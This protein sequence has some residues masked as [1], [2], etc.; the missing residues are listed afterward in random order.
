M[1]QTVIHRLPLVSSAHADG[2][3]LQKLKMDRRLG[4]FGTVW[5][6]WD[7]FL[8][9]TS[10]FRLATKP[11]SSPSAVAVG[12]FGSARP[13]RVVAGAASATLLLDQEEQMRPATIILACALL[14]S[15]ATGF[16]PANR[17]G[18]VQRRHVGRWSLPIRACAVGA[19][20]E[21]DAGEADAGLETANRVLLL[22]HIN[23]NHEKGRHDT[24]KAFYFDFLGCAIDPRKHENYL[25]GTKTVWANIGAS[26]SFVPLSC[27]TRNPTHRRLRRPP[28]ACSNSIYPRESPTRKCSTESSRLS[29]TTLK[30]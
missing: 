9:K 2:R 4:D 25:A 19:D 1:S 28:Q 26:N 5:G 29:M 21:A 15:T 20:V 14:L 27:C 8:M 6:F 17:C 24:L 12:R 30:I 18:V 10:L 3:P 16:T 13:H 23:I 11:S 22:D 7:R